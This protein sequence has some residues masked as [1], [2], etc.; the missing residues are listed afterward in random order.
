MSLA[1]SG[2]LLRYTEWQIYLPFSVSSRN[3]AVALS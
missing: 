3:T 1:E 2:N